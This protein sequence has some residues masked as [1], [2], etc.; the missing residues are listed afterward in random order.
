MCQTPEKNQEAKSKAHSLTVTE[1]VK[2]PSEIDW[3]GH[4]HTHTQISM[5]AELTQ[6]LAINIP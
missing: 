3:H 6:D 1:R 4:S 5:A 2:L